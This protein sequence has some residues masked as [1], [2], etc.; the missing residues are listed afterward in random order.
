MR[1]ADFLDR[2]ITRSLRD[3]EATIKAIAFFISLAVAAVGGAYA[4]WS[5]GLVRVPSREFTAVLIAA[6]VLL[7][8]TAF[9]AGRRSG[10][11]KDYRVIEAVY[12]FRIRSGVQPRYRW[13]RRKSIE[14]RR[15]GVRVIDFF[16]NWTG[17][18]ERL[19]TFESL[20]PEHTVF[21]GQRQE[22]NGR[23]YQWVYLGRALSKGEHAVAGIVGE[24]NDDVGPMRPLLALN[25][26]RPTARLEIVLEVE[27]PAL[28]SEVRAQA[29]KHGKLIGVFP[30]VQSVDSAAGVVRYTLVVPKPS[31]GRTYGFA[32]EGAEQARRS[33]TGDSADR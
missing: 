31:T 19:P 14:A 29:W 10:G 15:D 33:L 9:I 18:S 3:A 12:T 16:V 5:R 1:L 27:I 7:A 20:V 22:L 2:P 25:V 6:A 13:T 26:S 21:D 11:V 23:I 4:V 24:F 28:P 17:Q 32:W 8:V 30:V